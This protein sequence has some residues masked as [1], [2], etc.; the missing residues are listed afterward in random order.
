MDDQGRQ[1]WRN[2]LVGM[3][4]GVV[5][6]AATVYASKWAGWLVSLL[7]VG[8]GVWAWAKL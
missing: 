7:I 5:A 4:V 2:L 6:L 8:A 1:F 3:A